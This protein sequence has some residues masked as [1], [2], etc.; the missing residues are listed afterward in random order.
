MEYKLPIYTNVKEIIEERKI[1]Y[2]NQLNKIYPDLP[3]LTEADY[4]RI[5]TESDAGNKNVLTELINKSIYR[6]IEITARIYAH[7]DINNYLSIEDAVEHAIFQLSETYETKHNQLPSSLSDYL[8][9]TLNLLVYRKIAREYKKETSHFAHE[10]AM[11][12]DKLAWVVDKEKSTT[13]SDL[14]L[15]KEGFAKSLKKATNQLTEQEKR[16]IIMRYGLDTGIEMSCVEIAEQLGLTRARIH[17]ILK[18]ALIKLRQPGHAKYL[19][20]YDTIDMGN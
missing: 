5:K 12:I 14:N 2:L 4:E 19:K 11:N 20:I 10:E 17:G 16:V 7:Y 8:T 9:S 15:V 6:I 1:Q 18:S 13:I 3:R